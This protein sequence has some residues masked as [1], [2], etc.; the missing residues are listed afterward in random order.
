MQ[1]MLFTT[2][3]E[4]TAAAAALD[5]ISW[6]FYHKRGT[7]TGFGPKMHDVRVVIYRH[8]K[9]YRAHYPGQNYGVTDWQGIHKHTSVATL[10]EAKALA[11]EW[12]RAGI[13]AGYPSRY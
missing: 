13:A 9:V 10:K 6:K 12:A 2:T 5:I 4:T 3:P 8:N 7:V 11:T 1:D